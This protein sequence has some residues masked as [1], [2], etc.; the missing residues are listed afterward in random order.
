[1]K[2][3][4]W[5]RLDNAAKIFPSII[6]KRT[7]TIFRITCYTKEYVD[8]NL[9]SRAVSEIIERFPYY[10]VRL[11]RG[12]FWHYLQSNENDIIVLPETEDPC[13][14]ISYKKNNY[15]LFR[16]LYFKNKISVE[17]SH[18]LTDGTG[19]LIF[20]KSLVTHYFKL[21]GIQIKDYK[22]VFNPDGQPEVEEFEDSYRKHY[23][24]L[25]PNPRKKD[26]AFHVPEKLIDANKYNIITAEIS[27]FEVLKI[28]KKYKVSLTEFII[29]HYIYSIYK[30]IINKPEKITNKL[31]NPIRI[32]VPVNLRKI[33]KSSSMRNF[34]LT[35]TPGIDPRLGK[36]TYEEILQHVHHYMRVEVNDKFINQQIK[37]NVNGE[38]HPII[39]LVPLFIKVPIEQYIYY[40]KSAR[41]HSGV[42]TNLGKIDVPENIS[43]NINMF[44]FI[45]NPNSI[46]K[47]NMG[48]ISYNNKLNIT[49]ASLTNNTDIQ[50]IFFSELRKKGIHIKIFSNQ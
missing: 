49:L 25:I 42:I 36:Y 17:F 40:F 10:K 30:Y 23:N 34:F 31:L 29:A 24:N 13:R 37:R 50:Q 44:E 16:I 3:N 7:T 32:M 4:S 39:R 12:I 46:T 22:G 2:K 9:L 19:A 33:Y 18:I 38:K 15:Y 21:Q 20:L 47:I 6:T 26:K 1:M 35:V 43:N 27:S 14:K 11:K 48:V 8:P 45:P 28:S 41:E 5:F